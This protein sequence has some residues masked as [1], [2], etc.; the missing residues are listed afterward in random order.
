[1]P[2]FKYSAIDQSG[3][4]VNGTIESE[5]VTAVRD[6]LSE[7]HYYVSDITEVN[8]SKSGA[9]DFF[10]MFTRVKP[11]ELVVFSRQFATMI[12]AGLSVLKCLDILQ[13]QTKDPALA[14]ALAII[15][16]DVNGGASLTDA[17]GK[18]PRV[19]NKLYVNMIR[20]A[21]AG[22]ILD[23]VLDRLSTFLENDMDIKQKVKSAMMY[24]IVVGSFAIVILMVLMWYVLPQFK[25][26]FNNMG[27]TH[28]PPSTKFMLDFAVATRDYWY[29]VLLTI[30][31]II[32]G[33]YLYGRT[34]AGAMYLDT[35]KL[36]IPVFGDIILK[37]AISRFSRTFGTLIASGVP[38]LRAL[39][40]TTDTAGNLAISQII[41]RA[42]LSVKEGEKISDPLHGSKLFPL[43]VTQMIAIGEETGRLDQMLIKVSDFYDA[44]VESTLKGIA[45][46]I[47]PMMIAF[48]GVLVGFIAVSVISPIYT[49]IDSVK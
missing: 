5:N 36:K 9:T 44:E 2:T 35:L 10:K 28:M 26:I 25:E 38:I 8:V 30:I 11:K 13:R 21:E 1:M 37:L 41:E 39:E 29:V 23:N 16:R 22:G 47:E 12:D 45:S 34:Q 32:S 48:L 43:M 17:L 14:E 6:K 24:P 3:R 46:L 18:H 4:A 15:R 31:G 27:I 40:I 33:V 49:L 7:Q 42:R 19:F 20:S